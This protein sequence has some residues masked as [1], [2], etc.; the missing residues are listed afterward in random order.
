MSTRTT[1]HE[2]NRRKF[3]IDIRK[4]TSVTSFQIIDEGFYSLHLEIRVPSVL[5]NLEFPS[6]TDAT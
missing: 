3:H 2:M 6:S 1:Q 4:Y 5:P